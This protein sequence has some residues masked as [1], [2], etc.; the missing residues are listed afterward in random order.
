MQ[1]ESVPDPI[2]ITMRNCVIHFLN[3]RLETVVKIM[4]ERRAPLLKHF[5]V[6]KALGID[7]EMYCKAFY[8]NEQE[9]IIEQTGIWKGEWQHYFHGHGCRLTHVLTGE[10]FD[11][12]ASD[13][14][15]FRP[16][17]FIAHLQWRL[18]NQCD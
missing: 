15:Q 11:W 10:P 1:H 3:R 2:A 16:G 13:P 8:A 18:E 12:D 14:R 7:L 9:Y 4:I 17:E 6:D 5:G